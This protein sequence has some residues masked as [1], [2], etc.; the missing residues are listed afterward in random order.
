MQNT[1]ELQMLI[2]AYPFDYKDF[3]GVSSNFNRI[4]S[5]FKKDEDLSLLAIALNSG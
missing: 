4:I 2:R 5:R 3:R 1:A